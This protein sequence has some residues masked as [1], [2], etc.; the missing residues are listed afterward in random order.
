MARHPPPRDSPRDLEAVVALPDL[1]GAPTHGW[2]EFFIG[3]DVFEN[4]KGSPVVIELGRFPGANGETIA[5][6]ADLLPTP[7]VAAARDSWRVV[8][9]RNKK[10][11]KFTFADLD[12]DGAKREAIPEDSNPSGPEQ[13]PQGTALPGGRRRDDVAS[14]QFHQGQSLEEDDEK[15]H[16]IVPRIY[17]IEIGV[18]KTI[19]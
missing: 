7:F 5:G 8:Y 1:S 19:E 10:W 15:T 12:K 13:A 4:R 17:G 2:T 9:G 14:S 16:P 6:P 18:N 11:T 3:S